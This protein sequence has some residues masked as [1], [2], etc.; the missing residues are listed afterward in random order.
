MD[1]HIFLSKLCKSFSSISLNTGGDNTSVELHYIFYLLRWSKNS[2]YT[3]NL[4]YLRK[5]K[6]VI[7]MYTGWAKN[8]ASSE[9]S[10]GKNVANSIGGHFVCTIKNAGG[11]MKLLNTYS[12]YKGIKTQWSIYHSITVGPYGTF[13]RSKYW[14]LFL[15]LNLESH[16]STSH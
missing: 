13:Q 4:R 10:N 1:G 5:Q 7:S 9:I 15:F 8:V 2:T 14:A 11:K 12:W 3:L 6:N 16:T